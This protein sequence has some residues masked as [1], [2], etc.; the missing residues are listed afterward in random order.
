VTRQRLD[1]ELV[2]RGFVNTPDEAAEAIEA[3]RVTI[4]GRPALKPETLV[5][6]SEPVAI[7]SA[8]SR[9]ASRGG[10]KLA[11]ALDRFGVDPSG[12]VCL[13]AG[14]STGGFTDVLLSR[15]ASGVIAVDVGYGQLAWH[16]RTDE[17]VTVMER[18]NVRDLRPEDLPARPG[19]VTADL[20]FISLAMV[21]PALAA[22]ASDDADMI[23]LVKPQFE[24]ERGDVGRGG[25]VDDVSVWRHVLESVARACRSAGAPVMGSMA[26][27]LRGPAGNVE[28]FL[29]AKRGAVAPNDFGIEDALVE[30]LALREPK[31]AAS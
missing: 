3:G 17:R 22:L 14:S 4:A 24:A 31:G 1:G 16:L 15:G 6:A 20:S 8:G 5:S 29:H 27:P 12:R 23:F 11:A 30:G 25:V 10:D 21:T 9:Y 2:R 13:D 7:R 28:F 26:S 19:V 18:T